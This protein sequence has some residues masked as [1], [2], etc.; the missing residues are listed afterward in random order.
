[1][2][3]KNTF[4]KVL[5]VIIILVVLL[6]QNP[7]QMLYASSN[8]LAFLE[9]ELEIK[10]T[11]EADHPLNGYVTI[12]NNG[13]AIT[14][15]RFTSFLAGED[16]VSKEYPVKVAFSED[17]SCKVSKINS[18][19]VFEK[20]STTCITAYSISQFNI[21]LEN[22]FTEESMSGYLLVEAGGDVVSASIPLTLDLAPGLTIS[23][24]GLEEIGSDQ[25]INWGLLAALC[26]FLLICVLSIKK[27][28]KQNSVKKDKSA[29]KTIG[30]T[31]TN[32]LFKGMIVH[33][34]E[35]LK[36]WESTLTL[37]SGT[38]AAIISESLFPE[39]PT[40]LSKNAYQMLVLFFPI[41]VLIAAFAVTTL[42]NLTSKTE[43][44]KDIWE[45]E[46]EIT[47][48][49]VWPEVLCNLLVFTAFFG[50]VLLFILLFEELEIAEHLSAG[51]TNIS[52]GFLLFAAVLGFIF[53]SKSTSEAIS[54]AKLPEVRTK[55]SRSKEGAKQG[56][57]IDDYY[58]SSLP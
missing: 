54:K 15:L 55:A 25:I 24:L 4:F 35:W 34:I 5:I 14:D 19:E 44:V 31:F 33:Q 49:R 8:T 36:S 39:E 41:L 58:R 32:K 56:Y 23:L 47:I 9:E 30:N 21:Y 3:K 42:S 13:P 18:E 52:Q 43:T 40:I 17:E 51:A 1:M 27:I 11:P 20:E 46:K 45:V 57:P 50:E 12:Q 22:S 26:S 37:F 2:N 10:L 6:I 48:S 16:G 38:V 29:K 53:V 28:K 7:P